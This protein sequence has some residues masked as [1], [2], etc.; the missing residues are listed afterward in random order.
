MRS[1]VCEYYGAATGSLSYSPLRTVRELT[2]ED[3]GAALDLLATYQVA[4]VHLKGMIE[5]HGICSVKHRGHFYGYYEDDRLKGVALLGHA[6]MFCCGPAALPLFAAALVEGEIECRF[7][8]GPQTTV[9]AFQKYL[10]VFGYEVTLVRDFHWYVCREAR[11][12]VQQ[13]QLQRAD[14]NHLDAVAEAQADMLREATGSDPRESDPDGFRERVKDRIERGRTWVKVEGG[15]VIFKA[16]LQCITAEAIYLEGI[17]THPEQ[18]GRG[19]AKACVAELTHRRL[20][21]QQSICLVVE[22]EEKVAMHIYQ[23]AGFAHNDEYKACYLRRPVSE[24]RR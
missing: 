6:A 20:R 12:P 10:S 5:D 8:F 17:W 24:G 14:I 23:Q 2:E 16:E 1:G 13:L 3:Q 18:R 11:I 9:E 22:P 21:Q 7:V 19:V 4:S 15:K